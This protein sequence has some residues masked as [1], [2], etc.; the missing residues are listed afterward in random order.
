VSADWYE[1]AIDEV[2]RAAREVREAL[3][4]WDEDISEVRRRRRAGVP[5]VEMT[6]SAIA[7]GARDRRVAADDAMAAYRNAVM[8]LRAAV[9]C[10]LVD[11]EGMTL[12]AVAKLLR[13]SR[14][15][16]SRLYG[17]SRPGP[18]TAAARP[19]VDATM[20]SAERL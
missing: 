11:D 18:A 7:E 15:M 1:S 5:L 3:D 8:R 17:A 2:T 10:H 12:T 9:V 4:A 13:I 19:V 16:A 6:K 20:G 14:Q